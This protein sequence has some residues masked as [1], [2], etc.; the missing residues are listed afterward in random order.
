MPGHSSHIAQDSTGVCRP[1]PCRGRGGIT[2]VAAS[3]LT[4]HREPGQLQRDPRTAGTRSCCSQDQ[5]QDAT[6]P[7]GACRGPQ[8]AEPAHS[9]RLRGTGMQ[10]PPAQRALSRLTPPTSLLRDHTAGDLG[11]SVG[12]EV[13]GADP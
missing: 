10:Q 8:W 12:E 3:A 9:A 2:C 4:H 1:M 7:S 11:T 5:G 13:W 6:E